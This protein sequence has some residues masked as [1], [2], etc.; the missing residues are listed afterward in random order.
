[1]DA[2]YFRTIFDQMYW[3]RDRVLSAAA[4][5]SDEEY[6]APNGFTYKSVRGILTHC[7]S[8]ESN[9]M[10]RARGE[11]PGSFVRG[12]DLPTVGDL[13]ARWLEDEVKVREFL[14]GLKDKD[15][16][17]TVTFTGRDGNQRS[18]PLWHILQLVYHHTVQ[19]RSEAAEA[20]TMAGHS[21]GDMDFMVYM[22]A[23]AGA[24]R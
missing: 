11:A 15:L 17:K 13:T 18:M 4:A 19:H 22:A 10:A 16:T 9:W 24:G 20:L 21:P 7:L 6:A 12:E 23:K 5:L 1:M 3:A 2:E 8:G 14:A